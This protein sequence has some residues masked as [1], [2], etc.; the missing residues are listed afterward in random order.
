VDVFFAD[1]GLAETCAS[2]QAMQ[3][4]VGAVRARRL[5][6][7]LQQLR[8]VD[9]LA[10]MATLTARIHALAGEL[11][12]PLVLDLDAACRVLLEPATD[13]RADGGVDWSEVR[14]VVII[15]IT[16]RD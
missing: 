9:T 11:T 1:H 15:S 16:H 5:A 3:R 8:V 13:E 12:G 6:L 2:E 7:R 14:Q 4:R 10:D